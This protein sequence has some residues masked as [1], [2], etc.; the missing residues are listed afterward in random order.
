V[1]WGGG[2]RSLRKGGSALFL[3]ACCTSILAQQPITF[4]YFYD[5]LNQLSRVVDSTGIV[6]E[7]NYDG[8]GNIL[9]I[10][11][12]TISPGSLTI[13]NATPRAAATGGTIIIQGQGFSPDAALDRVTVG[14]APVTV[15]SATSTTLVLLIPNKGMSG[16]I[17]VMVGGSTAISD[18]SETV[19]LTPIISSVRPRAI[20][21]STVGV[22]STTLVVT[23]ANL[24]GS[25]FSFSPMIGLSITSANINPNGTSA[26]LSVTST[27]NLNGRFALVATTSIANSG[28]SVTSAN[29]FGAFTDPNADADN[30][31]LANA[32][33]LLLGTDPFNPDTD[34]DGFSDGVEVATGSDPLNPLC[35]PLNCRVSGQVESGVF[36][37]LNDAPFP[38]QFKEADSTTFSVLNGALPTG[39]FYE[40]DSVFFSVQNSATSNQPT[41]TSNRAK[42]T[43]R[44]EVTS[45]LLLDSD[46][47]GLSDEEERQLGT[48][49][50]N[51]DTDGDG[52]PDGLEVALGSD[53]LDPRSVPDIRP[54][55]TIAVPSVDVHNFAISGTQPGS[56]TLPTKGDQNVAQAVPARKHDRGSFG[57][58]H[59]LFR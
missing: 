33:E 37:T 8:V 40:A 20:Q 49:P 34:G 30:D 25:S 39:S 15:I 44:A 56:Q 14:G 35:T 24:T 6:I 36:S 28:L 52:Y 54:P 16:P 1:D 46:G 13:F 32:Y 38:G 2:R 53:P 21:A 4:Q 9:Q 7:Y 22:A 3:C 58:L 31:G 51:P 41:G 50:F 10:N 42:A 12:S 45:A 59:A 26:T 5:D 11:R 47:D 23:G 19:I 48:D 43:G 18:F 57:R 17:A 29:S 27:P 55:A